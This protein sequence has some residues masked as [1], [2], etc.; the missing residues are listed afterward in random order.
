MQDLYRLIG[1]P[2][3]ASREEIEAA[4][5][6]RIEEEQTKQDQGAPDAAIA[7]YHLSEA[8]SVLLD[9][10]R[11]KHYDNSLDHPAPQTPIKFEGHAGRENLAQCQACG[12]RVSKQA[13]AC[14]HC[15]QPL[16]ATT[17]SKTISGMV[18]GIIL[19][20]LIYW[21][22]HT[23]TH[24][25]PPTLG[26]RIAE[27]AKEQAKT[28][29]PAANPADQEARRQQRQAEAEQARQQR[30]AADRQPR[31]GDRTSEAFIIC[32]NLIEARLKSPK[33]ADFP[34][35]DFRAIHLG[36]ERYEVASYVDAKNSFGAEIRTRFW[37]T[38]QYTGPT[39]RGADALDSSHWRLIKLNTNP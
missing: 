12:G 11:R 18:G 24:R 7:L 20:A 5:S 39:T 10:T 26:E 27:M 34:L 19:L 37:C 21:G 35:F 1:I 29:P 14:P 4:I 31:L 3:N 9:A 8:R 33:S 6:R 32:K 25:A 13:Q 38:L 22:I 30:E 15:G 36:D 2:R 16:P 17:P 28:H 23:W